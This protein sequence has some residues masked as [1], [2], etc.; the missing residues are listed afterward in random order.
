MNETLR[1]YPV[2][3][4]NSRAALR[5]TTLPHGGGPDGNSPIAI[6]KDTVVNYSTLA[7]QHR[8]DLYPQSMLVGRTQDA[9]S[10]KP[11]APY[12]EFSPDRWDHWTPK[13]WQYVPFNGGPRICIEQQFALTEMGYT[14]TRI[15][16]HFERLE[17]RGNGHPGLHAEIVLAPANPVM[18]EFFEAKDQK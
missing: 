14:V 15:L 2:V 12:Y 7:L 16:Q 17:Y 11:F 8:E 6:L 4:Y 5:D 1:L 18:V 10:E 9:S 13:S 3:P